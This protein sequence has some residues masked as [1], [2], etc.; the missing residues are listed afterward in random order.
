VARGAQNLPRKGSKKTRRY[1]TH[2][3]AIRFAESADDLAR[4]ALILVLAY[5][6]LR[7]GEA[8]GLR[9]RDL[10][11]LRRRVNVNQSAVEVDGVIRVGPPKSWE[12]RCVPFPNF[13]TAPLAR[14]CEGKGPDDLVFC[15]A[16]GS[17]LRRP[18]TSAGTTSWFLVPLEMAGLERLTA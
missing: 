7:W 5:C 4:S 15:D 3:D 2:R 17:F 18:K 10:N 16:S 6:G 1:L 12:Q 14:L 11:M 8:I 13:L 9:V